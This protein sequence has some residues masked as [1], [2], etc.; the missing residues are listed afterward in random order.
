MIVF[1][2]KTGELLSS[3]AEQAAAPDIRDA[4]IVSLIAPFARL[5]APPGLSQHPQASTGQPGT[6][7]SPYVRIQPVGELADEIRASR[8]GGP[9]GQ[10]A[11]R[12]S[13]RPAAA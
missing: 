9:A 10:L 6:G 5:R 8:E 12:T 3:I 7:T 1:E 11:R 13:N 2:V 4:T